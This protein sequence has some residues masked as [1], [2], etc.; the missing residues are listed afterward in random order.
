MKFDRSSGILLHPT[1]LPGRFGIGDLGEEAYKFVDFLVESGQSL[2]QIMPLG[3]TGYGDSPYYSFSAF[4][5]NTNLISLDRLVEED[6]LSRSDLASFPALSTHRVDYGK[7]IKHKGALLE[8][9]YG[10]FKGSANNNR[11]EQLA[12]FYHYGESWLDNYALFSAIKDAHK[13]DGW[14]GWEQELSRRD[15]DAL[16]EARKRGG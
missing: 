1:S 2:W 5:G 10:N 3:P 8:K 13:G 9:A 4:A 16:H 6:L 11:R 14:N 15:P 12:G 7:V